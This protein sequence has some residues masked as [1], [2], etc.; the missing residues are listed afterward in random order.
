MSRIIALHTE[1]IKRLTAVKIT[2]DGNLVTIGGKNAAGKSS[3]LD[4]IEY[5]LGGSK[6]IPVDVI[7]RGASKAKTELVIDGDPPLVVTRRY[8]SKGTSVEIRKQGSGEKLTSPQSVLDAMSNRIA[9]DPLRFARSEPSEQARTLRGLVGLDFSDLDRQ[10]QELYTTRTQINRDAKDE[11]AVLAVMEPATDAPAEEVNTAALIDA[12]TEAQDHNKQLDALKQ[13]VEG[14]HASVAAHRKRRDIIASD[15]DSIEKQ[16][17]ELQDKL[18]VLADEDQK[19]LAAQEKIQGTIEIAEGSIETFQTIDEAALRIDLANANETNARVQA[20]AAY[21]QQVKRIEARLA[22]SE[23]ITEMIT[24]IDDRKQR[25]LADAKWPIEGLGFDEAG[26]TYNGLPFQNASSAEQ[27]RIS[28]A[29]GVAL[30]PQLSVFLVRDGSLL[31]SDSMAQLAE[32]ADAHNCQFWIERVG[33]DGDCAVIIEDGHVA[34][35]E[36]Q[37]EPNGPEEGSVP[38]EGSAPEHGLEASATEAHVEAKDAQ[39]P[40]I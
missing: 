5:A 37:P 12:I 24:T 16:I 11:Q 30:N 25:M 21:A 34:G 31:D 10:R 14:L 32:L 2:P 7:R 23:K 20:K 29:M 9:F 28:V 6:G 40:L 27:T 38:T 4:S 19:L 33:T 1:N 26:V 3:V 35:Q 39:R 22:E 17:L 15:K 18:I 13:E 8:S 36:L